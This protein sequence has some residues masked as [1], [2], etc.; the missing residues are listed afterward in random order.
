MSSSSSSSSASA[1]A[2]IV[3]ENPIDY[4][5]RERDFLYREIKKLDPDEVKEPVYCLPGTSKTRLIKAYE[6]ISNSTYAVPADCIQPPPVPPPVDEE[7]VVFQELAD[8]VDNQSV[9]EDPPAEPVAKTA[10]GRE[11]QSAGKGL[12]KDQLPKNPPPQ[13]PVEPKGGRKQPAGNIIKSVVET[14]RVNK[15]KRTRTED[16]HLGTNKRTRSDSSREPKEDQDYGDDF[17]EK[18]D[19]M[20][21]EEVRHSSILSHFYHRT[22]VMREQHVF[23]SVSQ[24]TKKEE[25][26]TR[27][28]CKICEGSKVNQCCLQCSYPAS[29][30][31]YHVCKDC[32]PKHIFAMC[33]EELF[34]VCKYLSP[35]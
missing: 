25:K 35:K 12:E 10:S 24:L 8:L 6:K 4:E 1:N 32:I 21:L 15:D 34:R 27:A 14:P 29:E 13:I 22:S 20:N 19:P 7:A 17:E 31:Y 26:T 5:A 9:P 30:E 33:D 2:P 23:V 11:D 3:Q 28:N 16:S 18:E